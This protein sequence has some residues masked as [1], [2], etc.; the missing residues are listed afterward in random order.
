MV[1]NGLK[2]AQTLQEYNAEHEPAR[3]IS[4]QTVCVCCLVQNV[5]LIHLFTCK[6]ASFLQ[7][8]SEIKT[9]HHK[10][11]QFFQYTQPSVFSVD[12]NTSFLQ[13]S[14]EYQEIGLERELD[15]L[16][17]RN[18]LPFN[19]SEGLEVNNT[20]LIIDNEGKV[21]SYTESARTFR[22]DNSIINANKC[23]KCQILYDEITLSDLEK[24]NQLPNNYVCPS[25][26]LEYNN[27]LSDNENGKLTYSDIKLERN[28][29]ELHVMCQTDSCHVR[30]DNENKYNDNE[31]DDYGNSCEY[32][33]NGTESDNV[34][35][36]VYNQNDNTIGEEKKKKRKKERT[37]FK[38]IILSLEE[39]KAE[40][41]A[42]RKEKKYLDAEFKCYNCAL[43]FLFKDTYQAHMMRHEESNGEYKCATCTLRFASPAVLRAHAQLHATRALCRRCGAR[44]SPRHTRHH[45]AKCRGS[46]A[47]C[48][49]CA[50]VFRDAAGLQQH[51]KRFHQSKT[52]LRSYSCSVCGKNYSNQ[53]AVRT[54]MIKHL[55]RK[56]T[57][58]LCSSTFSSPYTLNQHKKKHDAQAE[59]HYCEVCKIGYS[60]RKSLLAHRRN[61]LVHQQTVFECPVCARVCPNQRALTSHMT[62]V[63]STTKDHACDTCG[64]RYTSRKSLVRHVASHNKQ[65]TSETHACHRCPRTFKSRSKL[66]R[67]LKQVCEKDKLEEEL[68]CYYEGIYN[69]KE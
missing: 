17:Q 30:Y 16:R 65:P 7:L 56:F 29:T 37:G 14:K 50:R 69:V 3:I 34:N 64:A 12:S 11:L 2:M 13:E 10:N 58:D 22:E 61:A 52:S 49:L 21:I 31:Y 43:G 45:A 54:H 38:K 6:H 35:N 23:I 8:Q 24:N 42:K 20:N 41:E 63:H 19:R 15:D 59:Q 32:F 57:C 55:N 26:N 60:T 53:A 51:L 47:P 68:S 4:S 36:E 40:L 1:N 9:S 27:Q 67:H 25:C 48:H 66:N 39:Q 28:T 33:E 5:P 18:V 62:T 46:A 44:P